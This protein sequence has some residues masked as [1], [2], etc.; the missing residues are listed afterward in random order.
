M[1][2]PDPKG[3]RRNSAFEAQIAGGRAGIQEDAAHTIIST[4]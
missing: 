1:V 4:I 2:L 3:S